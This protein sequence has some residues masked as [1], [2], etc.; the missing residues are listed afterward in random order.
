MQDDLSETDEESEERILSTEGVSWDVETDIV[1]AGGGGAGLT[2]ALA[3]AE[4]TDA[5]VTVLEKEDHLGG[6]TVISSGMY[7][8]AGTRLQRRKGIEDS[9]ESFASD[10][11]E[12]NEN[13]ADEALVNKLAESSADLIHWLID[14]WNVNWVLKDDF[15][16]PNHSAYRFHAVNGEAGGT[17]V[18]ALSDRVE[19]TENIE[20]LVNTP[21]R[22]LVADGGRVAGVVAGKQRR[23]AIESDAVVL[24]TDGF[25][26]NKAMLREWC[27]SAADALY[28]GTDGNTG[29][30]IRLGADLGGELAYMDSYQAHAT[31]T[32]TGQK[33]PYAIQ[34]FGGI[35]VDSNGERIAD[36]ALG[37]ADF[38]VHLLERPDHTGYEI[39]DQRIYETVDGR[40]ETFAQAV[41]HNTYTSAWTIEGLGDA[42]GIDAAT[43]RRTIGSY[44][45]AIRNDEPD[46]VNRTE[47][48]HELEPPYYGAKVRPA[49]E[50]TQGGLKVDAAA[51]VCST[52]GATIDGLYAA[53]G[54]AMGISGHGPTGYLPGNGLT[55]ALGLGRIAGISARERVDE[56]AD[57]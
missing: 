9:P 50:Q 30:G 32:N 27:E 51:R 44:N 28:G 23:E 52:D 47:F 13:Q 41:K 2:A 11:L 21:V 56:N 18:D 55:A 26:G 17:L 53:G 35:I 25:G 16:Y 12:T 8:A 46:A 43:L 29:D 1:V 42:L 20:I 24:A 6:N 37:P 14:D 15:K 39:F 40:F 54:A 34:L 57:S 5:T 36:E 3:A 48:R 45:E 7:P 38:S 22:Q 49:L 19:R 4:R 33:S 10:I 31:W